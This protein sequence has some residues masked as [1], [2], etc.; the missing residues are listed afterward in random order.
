MKKMIGKT[1]KILVAV[2]LIAGAVYG[3]YRYTQAR[4]QAEKVEEVS[5]TRVEARTG[6]LSQQV[7]STG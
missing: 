5:Y 7:I 1:L 6:S 2:A 4:D 3:G